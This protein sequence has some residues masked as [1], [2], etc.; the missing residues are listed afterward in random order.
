M[1]VPHSVSSQDG[2][3]IVEF[4]WN[5]DRFSQQFR[6]DRVVVGSSIEGDS[7]QS[8]PISPPIQQLS[9]EVING[10][11]MVLGVG[12]AGRSHWSISASPCRQDPAAIRF[13]LACRCK[14]AAEFLGSSY[15]IAPALTLSVIDG[16]LQK[17]GD[18]SIVEASD[19]DEPT[20]QW[21]Y[22]I[23]RDPQIPQP[24]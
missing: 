24:A 15:R 10:Q 4:V 9:L 7:H 11:S 16:Q 12:G 1:P 17:K 3:L 5:G 18:V 6:L 8:W 23:T 20:R 19:S 22:A 13:D 2:R 14:E 21:S